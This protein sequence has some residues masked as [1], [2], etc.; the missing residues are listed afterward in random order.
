M[1]IKSLYLLASAIAAFVNAGSATALEPQG[2][3]IELSTKAEIDAAL[4]K[5]SNGL[6]TFRVPTD[7]NVTAILARRQKDGDVEVHDKLS[8]LLVGREGVA[9]LLIGGRHV[10]GREASP[11]EWRAGRIEGGRRVILGPGDMI[12]IPAGVP[13]QMLMIDGGSVVYLALKYQMTPVSPPAG[14]P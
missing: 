6:A 9:T 8:D 7:K 14:R 5:T 1:K 13:H 3:G 12:W 10:G 11:G 4:A 2:D